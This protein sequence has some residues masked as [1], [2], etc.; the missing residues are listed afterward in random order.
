ML[1]THVDCLSKSLLGVTSSEDDSVDCADKPH[2]IQF[3]RRPKV[4]IIQLV[5]TLPQ[6]NNRISR[7]GQHIVP[8]PVLP[9]DSRQC[10]L[11][12]DPLFRLLY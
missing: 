6:Q 11:G 10:P 1:L 12:R 9:P 2:R 3:N 5:I 8:L 4:E 7:C